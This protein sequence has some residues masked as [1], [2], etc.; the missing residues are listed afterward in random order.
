MSQKEYALVTGASRGIGAAIAKRLAQDGFHVFINFS[1]SE[2]HART[3]LNDIEKDGGSATLCGFD[4]GQADQIEEK[5][6]WI[7][8]DFGP[9]SVLVNNAGITRD[10]L[11][12]RMKNED[13]DKVLSVDLKGAMVCTRE[14]AK[15]M[16][17][18]RKGSIVQ[19]SSVVAE[20]GNPGQGVYCAAKAGL[21]GFSK[22]VAREMASRNIRVNVITPG[23]IRTEMTDKLTDPQKEAIVKNIPL[24]RYG[25]PNEIASLV[26]FLSS[27]QSQ[28]ITGQV[29]S[30]NG[31]L[32]M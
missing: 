3:V 5:M 19:I 12:V 22:S 4:V 32:Y 20:M 16:M 23:F 14:A 29:I 21:L 11:L 1:S 28:Y 18:T 9:L 26:S 30:V 27:D 7:A 6:S 25:E 2:D 10:G 31:G 17:K 8:K 15:Q 24:N 13:L